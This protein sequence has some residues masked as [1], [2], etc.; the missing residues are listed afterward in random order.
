MD[1]E[2][3]FVPRYITETVPQFPFGRRKKPFPRDQRELCL[4]TAWRLVE[5]GQTVLIFCPLRRYVESFA[6]LI[7]DLHSRG[8]LSSLLDGEADILDTAL[9]IGAEWFSS[10]YSLLACLKFG[11]AVHRGALPTSYRREVERLLRLGKLKIIISSPT[12]AQGFNL[13]ASDLVFHSLYRNK[14]LIDISEFRNLIG[15]AGRVF[16][17][18]EDQVLYGNLS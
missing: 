7:V 9:A 8:I 12:L 14:K 15:R 13:T 2:R 11:V 6:D 16:I 18:I 3:P 5:D 17:D 1:E 10:N 4:A